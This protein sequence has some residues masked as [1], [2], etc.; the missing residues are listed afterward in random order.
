[1]RSLL[2][3]FESANFSELLA[4]LL[5]HQVPYPAALVLAADSSGDLRLARGSRNLA[6]ALARGETASSGMQHV[7]FGTFPPMLRWVLASGQ[8]QGSLVESLRELGTLYRRRAEFE[9]EKLKILLPTIL[10]IG[11][12][13]SAVLFYSV[14]LFTPFEI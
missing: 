14:T 11:I 13:A 1:M 4:L 10:M 12:G 3:D 9:S 6:E 7:V 2:V 8:A 5:E